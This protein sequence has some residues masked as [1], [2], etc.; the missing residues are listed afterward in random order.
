MPC[1]GSPAEEARVALVPGGWEATG[2]RPSQATTT[3]MSRCAA[4]LH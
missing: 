3:E 4:L 2:R 1:E